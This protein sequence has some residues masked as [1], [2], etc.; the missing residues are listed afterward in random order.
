MPHRRVHI[1]GHYNKHYKREPNSPK[2]N[3]NVCAIVRIQDISRRFAQKRQIPN[4]SHKHIENNLQ[5]IRGQ[6]HLSDTNLGGANKS[7]GH[8]HNVYVTIKSEQEHGKSF[9]YS[10]V[11]V[12]PDDIPISTMVHMLSKQR[13]QI[14]RHDN[15][16]IKTATN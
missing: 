12:N 1:Q 8:R 16:D 2:Q 13:R 4:A 7:S 6:G 14:N 10:D 9:K 11:E 3:P 15:N 5:A